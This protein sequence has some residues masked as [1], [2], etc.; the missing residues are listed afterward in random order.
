MIQNVVVKQSNNTSTDFDVSTTTRNTSPWSHSQESSRTGNEASAMG[1]NHES[2]SRSTNVDTT[3]SLYS[4]LSFDRSLVD[5]Y[6]PVAPFPENRSLESRWTSS[7]TTEIRQILEEALDIA[8][9][10]D[11]I[12][13]QYDLNR[14]FSYLQ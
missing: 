6:D 1:N 8:L 12:F 7:N 10:S 14:R 2:R 3:M 11:L 13:D 9:T 4:L 5:L